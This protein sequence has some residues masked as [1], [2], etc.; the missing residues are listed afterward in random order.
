MDFDDADY[1]FKSL[2]DANILIEK[3][4]KEM[5]LR[6]KEV[7]LPEVIEFNYTEVKEWVAAGVEKYSKYENMIMDA[8]SVKIGKADRA[9]LNKVKEALNKERIRQEKEYMKPFNVFK[10][11]VNELIAMIDEPV[12]LIDSAVKGYE[13]EQKAHKE[14]TI[15]AIFEKEAAVA[16]AEI[17]LDKIWNDKWLNA[18]VSLK[19]VQEEIRARIEQFNADI[20]T[21]Q[22]L[23][24]FAF[25]A[26]ETYLQTLDINTAIAE[27]KRLSDMQKRKAEAEAAARMKSEEEAKAAAESKSAEHV[28]VEEVA[29]TKEVVQPSEPAKQWIGFKA[30]LTVD[31]ARELKQFFDSRN[32]QFMAV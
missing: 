20:E 23:P 3:E 21:L 19:K 22:N 10:S 31:Q 32:I 7:Q 28:P 2:I 6:V 16:T 8:D 29:A 17:R 24:E 14:A 18:S 9:E 11:Q 26:V 15:E 27:G 30:L 12:K 25:E 13:S 4:I 1:I 5:E